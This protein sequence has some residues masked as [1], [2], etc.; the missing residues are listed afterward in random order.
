MCKLAHWIVLT[1]AIGIVVCILSYVLSTFGMTS[2]SSSAT[3]NAGGIVCLVFICVASVCE[4]VGTLLILTRKN[5]PDITVND[6]QILLLAKNQ[7]K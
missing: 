2:T 3:Y 4:I 5:V 1:I 7:L 6:H